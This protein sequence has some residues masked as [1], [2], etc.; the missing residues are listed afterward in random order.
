MVEA[1]NVVGVVTFLA[2]HRKVA[3]CRFLI[4]CDNEPTVIAFNTGKAKCPVLLACL[5]QLFVI[6]SLNNIL[7]SAMH[8]TSE[9]M[10]LADSASRLY[11][12]NPV[13]KSAAAKIFQTE[14][15]PGRVDITPKVSELAHVLFN[16]AKWFKFSSM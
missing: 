2:N 11:H 10:R 3:N 13:K 6:C 1:I 7:V 15:L 16:P 4:Y 14:V 5:K 8:W 12:P 9:E